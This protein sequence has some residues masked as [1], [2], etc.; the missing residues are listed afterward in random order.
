MSTGP[1]YHNINKT[2][3]KTNINFKI[4]FKINMLKQMN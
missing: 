1:D 4:N 2:S 3:S